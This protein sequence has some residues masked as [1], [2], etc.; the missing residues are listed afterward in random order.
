MAASSSQERTGRRVSD[1][2]PSVVDWLKRA[3]VEG[4]NGLLKHCGS[5]EELLGKLDVFEDLLSYMVQDFKNL[6]EVELRPA[7]EALIAAGLMRHAEMDVRVSAAA[8]ISEIIRITAPDEP[9]A[10]D[11]MKEFFQLANSAF[12]KLACMSGRVYS[13]AV[14]IL[15]TISYSQSCVVM[16]DLEI[17]VVMQILTSI[18]SEKGYTTPGYTLVPCA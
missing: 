4:G 6:V 11:Q 8:C 17:A 16:L 10:E 9:Y 1:L 13:K 15:Q 5:T 14:S 12:E 18:F 3:L 7:K 2:D